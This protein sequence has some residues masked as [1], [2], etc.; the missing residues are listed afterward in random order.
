MVSS[1]NPENNLPTNGLWYGGIS[2]PVG[3]GLFIDQR[4]AE[5]RKAQL[6][7]DATKAEREKMLNQ[8][9]FDAINEYWQWTQL[10]NQLQI[11]EE[12]VELADLR[13]E[14]VKRG[15]ELGD[16]PAVDTLEAFI[17]LQN[18]QMMEYDVRLKYDQSTLKLSNYLWYEN[19]A[20]LEIEPALHPPALENLIDPE[21]IQADSVDNI[22]AGLS[23]NHPEM[24]LIDY[25]LEGV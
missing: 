6:F 19:N 7:V 5:L 22:I 20:P 24:K 8:L 17:Q 21:V 18:R 15:F 25:K 16:Q 4:R 1:L 10:W 9:F 12:M 13:F 11:Y 14:A 2:V 3:K 23:Q